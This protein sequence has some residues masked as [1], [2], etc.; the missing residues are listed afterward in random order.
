M[1]IA[2]TAAQRPQA[3]Y[4]ACWAQHL[5]RAGKPKVQRY[6][7]S[8]VRLALMP[9]VLFGIDSGPGSVLYRYVPVI[10]RPREAVA[11]APARAV[12]RAR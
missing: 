2:Q 10:H 12:P 5:R 6:G 3:V 11:V 4:R 7:T 9:A 1:A 8:L